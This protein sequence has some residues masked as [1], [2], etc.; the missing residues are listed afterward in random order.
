MTDAPL[1]S[2]QLLVRGITSTGAEVE[3][4][5]VVTVIDSQGPE[6]NI[7]FSDKFG[8][9]VYEITRNGLHQLTFQTVAIDTCEGELPAT[10][11]GGVSLSNGDQL[12][13]HATQ[14]EVILGTTE[15][16]VN[17]FATDSSGNESSE[18]ARLLIV[19]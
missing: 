4:A 17:A 7:S 3:V 16:S 12:A 11:T 1:G 14:Q 6:I 15:F 2:N 18:E 19:D 10:A 5:T 8:H 9:P 13:I